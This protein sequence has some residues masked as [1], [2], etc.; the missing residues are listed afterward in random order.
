MIKTVF[1]LTIILSAASKQSHLSIILPFS[2]FDRYIYCMQWV[3]FQK[4]CTRLYCGPVQNK[5]NPKLPVK[6][7]DAF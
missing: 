6:T 4:K 3:A 2:F 5:T 7:Q 1:Q